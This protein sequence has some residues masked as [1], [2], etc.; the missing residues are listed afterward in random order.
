MQVQ[1][2]LRNKRFSQKR[3]LMSAVVCSSLNL[4]GP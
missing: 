4:R 1:G 3:G 2:V